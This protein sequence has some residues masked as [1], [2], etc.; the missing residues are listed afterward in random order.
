MRKT[1]AF[2][3][4]LIAC[5]AC[6]ASE[7]LALEKCWELAREN[8]PAIRQFDLIK[9][10]ANFTIENAQTKYLPQLSASANAVYLSDSPAVMGNSAVPQD[11]YHMQLTATQVIWDGG[12]ISAQNKITAAQAKAEL[13]NNE[14]ALYAL[15][16]RVNRLF[17]GILLQTESLRQNEILQSDIREAI[18]QVKSQISHG[19]ANDYDL[20]MLEVELLR[21]KQDYTATQSNR[22][23]YL[24]MLSKFVG[25]AVADAAELETPAFPKDNNGAIARPELNWYAAGEDVFDARREAVNASLMP[26]IGLFGVAGYGKSNFDISDNR[27][28]FYGLVGIQVSVSFGNWYTEQS[29]KIRLIDEKRKISV[30]RDTFIFNTSLDASQRSRDVDKYSKLLAADA[31]IIRL[32]ENIKNASAARLKNGIITSRDYIKD[33]NAYDCAAQDFIF[34]K[35]QKLSSAYDKKFITNN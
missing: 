28:D 16:A 29:E 12:N 27:F 24:E 18:A 20:S 22:D 35:I 23:A 10:T 30:A 33:L 14:V 13:E 19:V 32:R 2:A 21:A 7:K 34:H 1:A 4:A 17:F 31:E 26:Q 5:A 6:S 8:Y 15:K 11:Q 25:R 3:A 9:R